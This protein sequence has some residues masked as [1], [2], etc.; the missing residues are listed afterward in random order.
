MFANLITHTPVP[1]D[2]KLVS[3]D[4]SSLYT[5]IPHHDGLKAALSSLI[6]HKEHDPM[7]PPVQILM[8]IVLKNNIFEF[9]G[10]YYLQLQGKAMG[11]KMAPSYANLFMGQLEPKLQAQAPHFIQM[12]KRYNIDDIFI[13]WTGSDDDLKHFMDKINSTHPTIK[14]NLKTK[15]PYCHLKQ[16]QKK[17]N[18]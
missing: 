15:K 11:T 6:D 8:S 4:V 3:I 13:I 10:D 17:N 2:C 1:K 9:N 5:N 7:R 14:F 18:H 16:H 12:W